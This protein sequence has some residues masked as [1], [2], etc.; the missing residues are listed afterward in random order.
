WLVRVEELGELKRI[1]GAHWKLE[2]G[3]ITELLA[4]R[5]PTPPPAVLFDKVPGYPPGFRTIFC[6]TGSIK[7]MALTLGLPIV[8][9]GIELVRAYRD[10]LRTLTPIPPKVVSDGPI[11]ENVDEGDRVNLLKFPVPLHHEQDGGRYIGTACIVMT[12]DPDEGWV[13]LGTY[14]GM[15]HDEKTVGV[16]ISPGKHGR[17]HRQKYFE[18]GKPCPVA[19]CVGQDPLLFL[20]AGNEV[21]Y[22]M[23]ELDYAGGFKGRP[24]EVIEGRYTGLPIPAHA[25][26]A[27]EGFMYPGEGKDEGPFGEWTGYY[28]S[29]ERS[30]PFIRV[31]AVYYR[32]DPI[33]TCARPSRP[34]S[35]YSFSKG[36]VKSALIWD[37]L[38]KIGIPNVKGVWCHEAGGGRLFNV[39]SIKQA[40]PGHARQ[41]ALA[42]AQTHAGAYLGRYVIVVDDDIDPSNTFDV[43][44]AIATRSDPAESI[45]IIRRAWSGPL[46]PRIR[47]GQKG[48]NSRAII[49][50]CRP[51]EWRDQFPPVAEASPE[52]LEETLRK[53]RGVLGL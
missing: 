24:I 4:R 16:Y 26:I 2:M 10:R 46:D 43:I 8:Q 3:A 51:Y 5:G 44:W 33:L 41:A 25:E 14:R 1:E 42:A 53:W 11:L 49:D 48:F 52:L 7:R 50:A 17:I 13:N 20:A 22:G 9:S 37:E 32:N 23:S 47:P 35:D 15:V 34:P 12:R 38:E 27:Y 19:V 31:Q 30:E 6:L 18:R 40:Y 39:V 45:D 21:P 28:A 29:G 36:I